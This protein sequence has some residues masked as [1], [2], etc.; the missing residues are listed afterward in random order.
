MDEYNK[1][2]HSIL[3]IMNQPTNL[4]LAPQ[5]EE[6]LEILKMMYDEEEASVGANMNSI[7][8]SPQTI[9]KKMDMKEEDLVPIL[10]RMADKGTVLCLREKESSLYGIFPT[11]IGI[12]ETAFGRGED[13]EKTRKLAKLWIQYYDGPWHEA[14]HT[15]KTSMGR[16]IP[17]EANI[18]AQ[19][20]VLPYEKV[21]EIIERTTFRSV[22]N[23]ACKSAK[24][25]AGEGCSLNAP[26]EVCMFF[27]E[28]GRSFVERGFARE[29]SKEEC[30]EIVRKAEDAGLVHFTVNTKDGTDMLCNCCPCCCVALRGITVLKKPDAVAHSAYFAVIDRDICD[31]CTICME[32]CPMDAISM[33]DEVVF[34]NAKK[35]IGCGICAHFCPREGAVV[36]MK[37]KNII[38]PKEDIADLMT[39]LISERGES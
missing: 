12:F 37:R 30:Y 13:S 24:I 14:F 7:P 36:L 11:D 5:S 31:G 38:E 16:V 35:C 23:C 39:T 33:H 4:I 19:Q 32:H 27:E 15:S 22:T 21:S 6:I 25:L 29:I 10:E 1:N 2:I 20:E 8:E 28:L 18:S 34:A 17:V 9:A 3:G 26:T